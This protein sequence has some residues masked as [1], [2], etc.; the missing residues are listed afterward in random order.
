MPPTHHSIW[1]IFGGWLRRLPPPLPPPPPPLL[2]TLRPPL[3]MLCG[4]MVLP[5]GGVKEKVIAAR[6]AQVEHLLLP[7]ANRKDW[8]E[9][10]GSLQDGLTVHFVRNYE[11]VFDVCFP[12]AA[13]DSAGG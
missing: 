5:I 13:A 11:E 12:P 1:L 4:R 7:D 2:T 6:Q 3:P 9:L 8:D 10:D